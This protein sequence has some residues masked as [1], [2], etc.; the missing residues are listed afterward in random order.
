MTTA[1]GHSI[2]V[3]DWVVTRHNDR[4]LTDGRTWVRNGDR[5]TVTETNPDGTVTV[6]RSGSPGQVTLPQD[7]VA[8]H[9]DLAYAT[10]AHRSQGRTVDCTHTLI[11]A[12]T[13]REVLYVA[14]TRGRHDNHLYV[15]TAYDPDPHTSHGQP[16]ETSPHAV[17]AAVLANPG[18]ETSAHQAMR[19]NQR[20]AESWATLAAEYH[21]LATRAHAERWDNLV[22]HSGLSH[23]QL[24]KV[25][26]ARTWIP[27]DHLADLSARRGRH[28]DRR[29]GEGRVTHLRG[30]IPGSRSEGG[31]ID[32]VI[33]L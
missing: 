12:S 20:D 4:H 11:D 30:L 14:A 7:Y 32:L 24:Q 22:A 8:E 10:T 29:R 5:W 1:C 18:A 17:L 3:G 15:D 16:P 9:L 31:R 13:T 2:G 21:T 6:R 33:K 28:A 27:N 25:T 26:E 19:Q 23:E